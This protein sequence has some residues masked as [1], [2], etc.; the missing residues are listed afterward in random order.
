M[1]HR[2]TG[3]VNLVEWPLVH[4][5]SQLAEHEGIRCDLSP[6]LLTVHEALHFSTLSTSTSWSTVSCSTTPT[7]W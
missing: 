4:L 1:S 2:L 3:F 7:P 5:A 6:F